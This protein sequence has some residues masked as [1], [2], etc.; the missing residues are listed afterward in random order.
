MAE[1]RYGQFTTPLSV[2]QGPRGPCTF[3]PTRGRCRPLL[4]QQPAA[5]QLPTTAGRGMFTGGGGAA[6]GGTATT[7]GATPTG[8]TAMGAEYG[9]GRWGIARG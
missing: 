9:D 3:G 7:P 4:S 1:G 6:T 5:S 2:V 8:G